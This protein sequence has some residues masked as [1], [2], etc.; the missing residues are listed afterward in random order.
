MLVVKVELHSAVTGE[1]TELG[2]A[3][4]ANEGTGTPDHGNYNVSIGRKGQTGNI[5]I[6]SKPVRRGYVRQHARLSSSVW[7]LVR[8]SLEAAGF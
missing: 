4:I 5:A 6:F 1:V 3:I 7:I 8:K 2:R